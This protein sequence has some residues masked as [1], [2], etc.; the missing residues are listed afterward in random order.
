MTTANTIKTDKKTNKPAAKKVAKK[1]NVA[2]V[3]V[4]A[5]KK[6][7]AK[8]AKKIKKVENVSVVVDPQKKIKVTNVVTKEVTKVVNL[9]KIRRV[10]E[11]VDYVAP[12]KKEKTAADNFRMAGRIVTRSTHGKMQQRS[13]GTRRL[14]NEYGH[15]IG[16]IGAKIDMLIGQGCWTKKQI[17]ASAGTKMSKVNSHINHLRKEKGFLVDIVKGTKIVKFAKIA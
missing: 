13:T 7:V 15:F 12:E 16:T 17:E 11:I 3:A 10:Q 9:P 8:K 1:V 4:K 5:K 6:V 14:K 2:N